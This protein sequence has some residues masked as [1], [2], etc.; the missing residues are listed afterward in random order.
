MPRRAAQGSGTIRKKT[1][2]RKGKTYTYWE[3]RYTAGRDSGTGKQIQRSITG[4]TQK[5]VAQKLKEATL[6][7]D[8]GVYVD[9]TKMSVGAWLDTWVKEY[10]GGVKPNTLRIYQ[11]NVEKHIKPA[12]AALRLQDLRPHTIQQFVNSL[13]LAPSSIRL[14]YKVL[15]QALEKAVKLGY[16][17]RNPAADC[18][19]PRVCLKNKSCTK[20]ADMRN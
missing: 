11:S 14:A 8:R 10:L 4:K 9:P 19:L 17:P 18:E 20:G 2:I 12:L 7:V 16:L 15:H 6:A 3:A 5:E 13:E 1:V